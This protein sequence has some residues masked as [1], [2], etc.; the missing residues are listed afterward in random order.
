[1]QANELVALQ[2]LTQAQR[3]YVLLKMTSQKD[4]GM[5]YLWWFIFGVHYFYLRKP[6][7]N[8]LYW[9]TASG[10]GIWG[11]IDLFRIPGMVRRFNEKMLKEAIL[12]AQNLY[13]DD[14]E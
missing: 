10:F 8:L 7:I 6:I 14:S 13:P 4:T 5:A 1:M 2:N 3:D 9:V 11:I 12:E